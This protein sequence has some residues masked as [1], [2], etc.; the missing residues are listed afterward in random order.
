MRMKQYMKNWLDDQFDRA[1][2]IPIAFHG[3]SS[4]QY[5]LCIARMVLFTI[6][7]KIEV[8]GALNPISTSTC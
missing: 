4:N 8:D 6:S 5:A 3:W 7:Y 2:V 1:Q